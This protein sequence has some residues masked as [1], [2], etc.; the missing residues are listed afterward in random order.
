MSLVNNVTNGLALS[1]WYNLEC[2]TYDKEVNV[3][4]EIKRLFTL[5]LEKDTD[6]EFIMF[7]VSFFFLKLSTVT[8]YVFGFYTFLILAV[9]GREHSTPTIQHKKTNCRT[10]QR[11]GRYKMVLILIHLCWVVLLW[12][13][14]VPWFVLRLSV[15]KVNNRWSVCLRTDVIRNHFVGI[16]LLTSCYEPLFWS[17][18]KVK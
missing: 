8:F 11:D 17:S 12:M 18:Y 5:F 15:L 13:V 10:F 2:D 1:H 16:I 9:Y 6:I 4:I 7:F 14:M 3:I